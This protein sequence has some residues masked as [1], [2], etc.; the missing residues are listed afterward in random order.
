MIPILYHKAESDFSHN[1]IGFLKDAVKCTVTEERNG[2]YELSL[3]Y[4][5]TG[6]FYEQI[7]HGAIVKAKANQTSTLQL[8]RIYKSSKPINGI[9]TYSGEHISYD[10]NGIPTPG[11]TVKNETPQAAITRGIDNALLPCPFT[12]ISDITTLNSTEIKKPCSVRGILGGQTGS[13]LDVWGGEYEFDNFVIKLHKHRGTDNGVTIEYGKNLTDLKQEASIAECYTHL[14]PYAVYTEELEEGESREF[15]VYLSEKIIPLATAENIGHSKA[16]IMD[17]TDRFGEDEE[18]NEE[19][20]RAKATAYA[21]ATDLGIP[22]VNITVSFIPL[23]QT[24]EYK[25]IAPLER[26]N[27]CDT[28]KVYFSKLGVNASAKAIKTVYDSLKE[29][30]ESVTLGDAKSSFAD[31]VNEQQ[32]T[33]EEIKDSVRRTQ[34]KAAEELKKAILTATNLIT[35]HSGGYVVL[36]PAEKPQEILILDA[37]TIEEAVNVWRWNSGGL[38]YS[39]TGYNGKY[40]LAMTMDGSIVADFITAGELNGNIIKAATIKA[41]AISAETFRIIFNT[42]SDY[43]LFE[44]GQLKIIN[45]SD[46][47]SV[48][49]GKNGLQVFNGDIAIYKGNNIYSTPA[50]LLD[51]NGDLAL[52]GYLTQ[53]GNPTR[54]LVGTNDM[55][56]S[57]VFIYNRSDYYKK[58]DGTYAPYI[59]FWRSTDNNSIMTGIKSLRFA[60]QDVNPDS[61]SVYHRLEVKPNGGHFQGLWTFGQEQDFGANIGANSFKIKSDSTLIG[62]IYNSTGNNMCLFSNNG[63]PVLIGVKGNT[64]IEAKNG[65]GSLCGQWSIGTYDLRSGTTIRVDNTNV[66]ATWWDSDNCILTNANSGWSWGISVG[67]SYRIKATSSGVTLWGAVDFQQDQFFDVNIGSSGGFVLQN[68]SGGTRYGSF[69]VSSANEPCFNSDTGADFN[70]CVSSYSKMTLT[71][72]GGQLYGTWYGTSS[73]AIPSDENQKHDIEE[74]PEIYRVLFDLL[75][76]VRYKYNDG[77]SDRFHTGFIAQDVEQALADAELPS[78][79]F[80][81]FIKDADGNYFL[82]YEEFIALCVNE[83]QSLKKENTELKNKVDSLENK[84]ADLENKL[85]TIMEKL[86]V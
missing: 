72:S 51:S 78:K 75:K 6:Q 67:N 36:N 2:S 24:E 38:G 57:G 44:N 12:A 11:L 9:V 25:N 30:Y 8:F 77:E 62:S 33:I 46:N 49:L 17:F 81:G 71:S 54:L 37:P 20:L 85:N 35:G 56:Y 53:Y 40:S 82:R 39:S 7:T 58:T 66:G 18:I 32:A 84:V 3:Q 52:D 50:I 69:Y 16:Y 14:A 61:S 28:V 10:L 86:E 83:I 31:T 60:V 43:I 4:P 79:D 73:Q 13:V 74:L 19:S 5:I 34:A 76:P 48:V 65:G 64:A 29:K 59:E 80:A 68:G 22:K 1:G 47:E 42:V 41:D 26:V 21:A 15:Y 23:W 55:G 27:L 70:F 63:N 45:S